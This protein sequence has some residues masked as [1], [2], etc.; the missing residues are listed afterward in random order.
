MHGNDY[1]CSTD[2]CVPSVTVPSDNQPTEYDPWLTFLNLDIYI[3]VEI[4][5][6]QT[7]VVKSAVHVSVRVHKRWDLARSA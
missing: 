5:T 7:V 3:V 2:V 4:N 6:V 1:N